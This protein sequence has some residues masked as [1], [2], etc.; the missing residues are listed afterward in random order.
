MF[1]CEH[2]HVCD[3]NIK[4]KNEEYCDCYKNVAN[5]LSSCNGCGNRYDCDMSDYNRPRQKV[6]R[7]D[8]DI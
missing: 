2:E 6:A 4:L 1:Y 5:C 8:N 3:K 7:Y